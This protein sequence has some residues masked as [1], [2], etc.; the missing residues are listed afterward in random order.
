M[1]AQKL[2]PL[3]PTSYCSG[4]ILDII[5]DID[6]ILNILPARSWEMRYCALVPTS[7]CSGNIL[8]IL[9]NTKNILNILPDLSWEVR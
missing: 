8:D 5:N 7:N 2:L 9:N 4:N 1:P 6:N 3:A